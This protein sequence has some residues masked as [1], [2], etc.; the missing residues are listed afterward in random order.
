MEETQLDSNINRFM[1]AK[2]RAKRLIQMDNN[3]SLDKIKRKAINE[4]KMSYNEDGSVTLQQDNNTPHNTYPNNNFIN[5]KSKLPTEI[6]E[7]F[8]TL[9]INPNYG[10]NGN[11][12]IL[13]KVNAESG[14]KLFENNDI[15]NDSPKEVTVTPNINQQ[16]DYSMIKMIVEDCLRKQLSAIKKT[17]ISENVN[18]TNDG[19]TIKAM[20]LGNKFS[21]ITENGDIYEAKLKYISNINKNSGK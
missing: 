19:N 21:F 7:S 1:L 8:K 13:D 12:S 10:Y 20:K 3:G 9:Q 11:E 18:K 2:E 15:K 16:I 14:G 17:M 4:G 5:T 6:I